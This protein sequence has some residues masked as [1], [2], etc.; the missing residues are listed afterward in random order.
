MSS[1]QYA[2][3]RSMTQEELNEQLRLS[4]DD[5][6]KLRF[7]LAMRQLQNTAKLGQVRHRIAQVHTALQE[8]EVA[9][10]GGK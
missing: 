2:E 9:K 3:L 7:Q 1:K 8:L 4:K 5:L 10:K 6:F